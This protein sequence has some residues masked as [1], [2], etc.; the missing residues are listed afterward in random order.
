MSSGKRVHTMSISNSTWT[1]NYNL[2]M[3]VNA[4]TLSLTRHIPSSLSPYPN[5]N[6]HDCYFTAMLKEFK[7]KIESPS[8]N[9]EQC[10]QILFIMANVCN[11]YKAMAMQTHC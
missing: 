7:I 10:C 3:K 4:N 6:A 9:I 1:S 11:I 8:K 2:N 5:P